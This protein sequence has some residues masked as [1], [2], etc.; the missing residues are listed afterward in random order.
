MI[1]LGRLIS[2]PV[3]LVFLVLL[4]LTLVLLRVSNT[5][6]D[7]GYYSEELDKA[8]VYEFAL[9]DALVLAIDEYRQRPAPEGLDENPLTTSGLSTEDIVSSVNRA[10]P[11]EWVQELVDQSFDQ[12]GRYLTGERDEFEVTVRAGDRAEQLVEEVKGLMRKADAY[13]LLFKRVVDPRVRDAVAPGQKLPLGVEFP[14]DRLVESVRTIVP[15]AW[16]QGQGSRPV[17]WCKSTSSC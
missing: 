7:P 4:L 1:W 6:L 2:V 10:L 16:V 14:P 11:P 9:N 17:K 5:F 8:N 15:P 13:E 12:V 3:G